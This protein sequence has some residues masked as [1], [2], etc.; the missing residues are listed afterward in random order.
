MALVLVV[1]DNRDSLDVFAE[2]L[3][4]NGHG[5]MT[6]TSAADAEQLVA[7]AV[8]DVALIDIYLPERDGLALIRTLRRTHPRLPIIAI[9]GGSIEHHPSDVLEEAIVLGAA[10]ILRKP[11]QA[12]DL[13]DLV[14]RL[15]A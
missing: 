1:D 15:A 7:I 11:V 12:D 13:F 4:L 9:S 14:R 10:A 2:L 6:A 8:P 3:T 5:V